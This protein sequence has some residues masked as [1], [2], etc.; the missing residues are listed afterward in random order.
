MIPY[1]KY[2]VTF[3]VFSNYTTHS[4]Q[5]VITYR[6]TLFYSSIQTQKTVI[7]DND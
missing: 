2:L 6:D 3:G 4:N 5:I 1:A 7:P